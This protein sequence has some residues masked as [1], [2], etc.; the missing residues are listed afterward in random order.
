MRALPL[1]LCVGL[2]TINACTSDKDD[3]SSD[4]VG[5][6]SDTTDDSATDDS[7]AD[8][9]TADDSTADD[10]TTDDSEVEDCDPGFEPDGAG[11]CQD[12]DE[13][14]DGSDDCATDASCTNAEGS[15]ACECPSDMFGDGFECRPIWEDVLTIPGRD[16]T[17]GWG[18]VVFGFEGEIYFAPEGDTYFSSVHPDTG[19][20]T[21]YPMPPT[22]GTQSDWCACGYTEVVVPLDDAVYVFGN[23]GQVF[24]AGAW[25]NISSYSPNARGEAGGASAS[26]KVY[27]VGGRGD[28][29]TVQTYSGGVS[30]T[31]QTL[32]AT[33]PW[34][35]NRGVAYTPVGSETI[36]VFG[37]YNN[38]GDLTQ[39]ASLDTSDPSASWMPTAAAPAS[40]YNDYGRAGEHDGKILLSDGY[41]GL[42]V[43]APSIDVWS[44]VVVPFPEGG[45]GDWFITALDGTTYA[46]GQVGG[47]IALKR[48]L[49][50]Q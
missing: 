1:W 19:V 12:I 44:D 18:A 5:A 6:D 50:I 21:D 35:Y 46:L 42:Y 30:G 10:S 27:M 11:G 20:V 43:Y 47:D 48:L 17:V 31:W 9:S 3:V 40:F 36:Y 45:T 32:A 28:L 4:S 24:R 49:N 14:A 29:D 37:G 39:G 13:C 41:N 26:G 15:Y 8:D 25:T 33:Y 23:W 2:F 34:P 7:T 38:D 16:L 22:Y